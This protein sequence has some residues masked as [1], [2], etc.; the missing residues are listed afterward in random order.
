MRWRSAA[1]RADFRAGE[2]RE[3]LR[4][5]A[6]RAPISGP[7]HQRVRKLRVVRERADDLRG[8]GAVLERVVRRRTGFFR[9]GTHAGDRGEDGWRTE[10][11]GFHRKFRGCRRSE[12]VERLCVSSLAVC[13]YHTCLIFPAN[14][15]RP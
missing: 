6:V 4:R 12:S 2:L 15:G 1:T 5:E 10:L 9:G 13:S 7:Q 14:H 11:N 3:L 8:L